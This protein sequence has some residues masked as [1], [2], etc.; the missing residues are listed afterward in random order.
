MSRPFISINMAATVDGKITSAAREHPRMTSIYDRER[1]DRL[2]AESDAVLVG[3]GTMRAD[4]P[5][6]HVRSSAM[7]KYR[8]SLGKSDGLLK[9]LVTASL[10]LDRS[11]RFAADA[12]GG[13]Q[14]I[15]TVENAPA[16]RVKFW[17]EFAE[18]WA[19]GQG[20]VDLPEFLRRLTER[21]VERLL[22]EGGG[23][24]NWEFIRQDLVD[25]IHVTIAPTLLGGR[26][27]PTLLEGDG[28]T[29]QQQ[30]RL[31]LVDVQRE[32]DEIYCQWDVIRDSEKR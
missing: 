10:E 8:R 9:I 30:Q 18:V 20:R 4:N 17:S 11:S 12:D 28:F 31:R 25:R 26:D 3:A 19:I 16:D 32:C 15:V 29:M 22:V 21:G 27:A 6:L 1:M 24:L 14:L 5:K 13:G 7:Q 23:E 2:R